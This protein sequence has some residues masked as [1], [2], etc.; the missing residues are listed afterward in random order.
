MIVVD[1]DN[2]PLRAIRDGDVV[3]AFT[4][5]PMWAEMFHADLWNVWLPADLEPARRPP[6]PRLLLPQASRA[7]AL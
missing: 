3:R 7:S 1:A 5:D 6:P 2:H 4:R